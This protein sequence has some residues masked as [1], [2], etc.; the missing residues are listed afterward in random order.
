MIEH[1]GEHVFPDDT[2]EEYEYEYGYNS[3]I[4]TLQNMKMVKFE[5]FFDKLIWQ[6]DE[7]KKEAIKAALDKYEFKGV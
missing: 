4:K 7:T 5:D 6:L 1:I 2:E 3:V